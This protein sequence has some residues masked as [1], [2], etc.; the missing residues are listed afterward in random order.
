MNRPIPGGPLVDVE[1]MR[2]VSVTLTL[3]E[4]SRFKAQAALRG[5]KMDAILRRAVADYC[6]DLARPPLSKAQK[7]EQRRVNRITSLIEKR[8]AEFVQPEERFTAATLFERIHAASSA[9]TQPSR[10]DLVF[11]GEDRLRSMLTQKSGTGRG[12]LAHGDGFFSLRTRPADRI[13]AEGGSAS[14]AV[15]PRRRKLAA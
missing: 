9:T 3:S 10:A 4:H 5:E 6:A 2:K 8:A 14:T 7:A 13:G 12:F 15:R 11:L 1:P